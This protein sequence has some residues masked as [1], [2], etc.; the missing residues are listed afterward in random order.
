[1]YD[2]TACMNKFPLKHSVSSWAFGTGY[3]EVLSLVWFT[4]PQM[5]LEHVE[6]FPKISSSHSRFLFSYMPTNV[7]QTPLMKVFRIIPEF[8]NLK[9]DLP[10]KV[11]LKAEY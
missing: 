6:C 8:R 9:G 3:F 7:K 2:L 11:S 4:F 1:M 5:Y 10:Q